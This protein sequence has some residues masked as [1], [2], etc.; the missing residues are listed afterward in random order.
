MHADIAVEEA[1]TFEVLTTKVGD[2]GS[3]MIPI[4]VGGSKL[5]RGVLELGASINMMPLALYEKLGLV[6]LKPTVMK[7][8]L[9]DQTSRTPYG[10]IKDI[11]NFV[12]GIVIHT[13]FVVLN[14][15]EKSNDEGSCQVLLGRSFMATAQ[16]RID[17]CKKKIVMQSQV[18][19]LKAERDALKEQVDAYVKKNDKLK[20][21]NMALSTENESTVQELEDLSK[22]AEEFEEEAFRKLKK[23]STSV[24]T[25][26]KE[27]EAIKE[28]MSNKEMSLKMT[29][30][31]ECE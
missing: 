6:G 1:M 9:A 31:K 19:V 23:A 11:P 30:A 16:M 27:L 21:I 28:G 20:K 14:I 4:S 22:L 10:E 29:N 2:S 24:D 25:K 8:L 5:L 13:D 7:I 15:E 17:M 12:G 18:E 26:N 3:F